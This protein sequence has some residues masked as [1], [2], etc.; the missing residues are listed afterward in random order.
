MIITLIA[1][2]VLIFSGQIAFSGYW[3]SPV[4]PG[5]RLLFSVVGFAALGF[6]A[7]KNIHLAIGATVVFLIILIYEGYRAKNV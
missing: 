6:F 7:L 1:A 2:I 3:L 5:K 4:P